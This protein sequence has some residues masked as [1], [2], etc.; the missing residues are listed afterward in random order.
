M[1]NR[2]R[3]AFVCKSIAAALLGVTLLLIGENPVLAQNARK[4]CLEK[5]GDAAIAACTEAIRQ[6]PKDSASF[7]NRGFEYNAKGDNERAIADFN[8][9]IRLD[10]KDADALLNRGIAFRDKGELDRAIADYNEAIRLNPK[11]AKAFFSRGVAYR[12]KGDND[13]AIADYS[14]V[15]RIDPTLSEPF[16][17]RGLVYVDQKKYDRAMADY[18]EAIRLGPTN[19]AAYSNR[20]VLHY[21]LR[22]YEKSLA[23]FNEAI[24]LKPH[25]S[26]ALY[27]RGLVYLALKN[28]RN[29]AIADFRTASQLG[30]AN[31][32][33]KLREMAVAEDHCLVDS[34]V[35]V[36]G[37]IERV[38]QRPDG[39]EWAFTIR[40]KKSEPCNV[41]G[42]ILSDRVQPSACQPGRTITATGKIHLFN[43][44]NPNS[45]IVFTKNVE[46]R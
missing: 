7:N 39:A 9:A 16:N 28:E 1:P 17:N 5:S 34:T 38:K 41:D 14:E 42:V 22:N 24:G 36:T 21:Y 15:I 37:I 2:S 35:T 18:N 26:D 8:E 40:D 45:Q 33:R 44:N 4:D 10:P 11:E 3:S 20:G 43:P 31:A 32:K 13:R 30:E 27:S 6:N 19:E 29:R 46:C 23:D 12:A 25:F